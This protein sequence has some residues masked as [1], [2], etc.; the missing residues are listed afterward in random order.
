MQRVHQP[1]LGRCTAFIR[2]SRRRRRP[3]PTSPPNSLTARADDGVEKYEA[4][5]LW[6][7]EYKRIN[8]A[9]PSLW[10]DKACINQARIDESL[11]MLPVFLGGC[12]RLCVVSGPTYSSRLW[13]VLELYT[14]LQIHGAGAFN[15]LDVVL[16]ESETP[17]ETVLR[18]ER[19]DVGE[20]ECFL[21][22]DKAR[23]LAV[24][25]ASY[26]ELAKF[27]AHLRSLLVGRLQTLFE[28]SLRLSEEDSL[29]VREDSAKMSPSARRPLTTGE[30]SAS[31]GSAGES[32]GRDKVF[33]FDGLFQGHAK[34]K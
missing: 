3:P 19:F 8:A 17:S 26:G 31:V 21:S 4:L 15:F 29:S 9:A 1:Q 16:L 20:C 25:E 24:I 5:S 30:S 6:A 34:A 2:H 28:Q 22:E 33:S 12:Q 10:L 14:F 7:D 27:S 32:S 18:F 13:C 11:A 23:L